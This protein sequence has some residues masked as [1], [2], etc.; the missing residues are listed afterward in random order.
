MRS[1]F[2]GH[3]APLEEEPEPV[4]SPYDDVDLELDEYDFELIK[5]EVEDE[6][7]Q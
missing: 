7:D 2:L 5:D 4:Y 6:G 3:P 1:K